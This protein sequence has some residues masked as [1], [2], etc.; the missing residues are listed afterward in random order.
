[1]DIFRAIVMK[2][3][4]SQTISHIVYKVELRFDGLMSSSGAGTVYPSG[5][6]EVTPGF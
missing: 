6:P 4:R 2:R 3:T 1:V 5:A